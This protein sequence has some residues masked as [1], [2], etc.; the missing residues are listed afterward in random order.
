M[1]TTE[2]IDIKSLIKRK[3]DQYTQEHTESDHT[4]HIPVMGLAFTIDAPAKVG[5]FGISSVLSIIEDRLI[6]MMRANYYPKLGL[7]YEPITKQEPD[8]RA[9]RV[10]DYLNLLQATVYDQ[11]SKLKT[12]A[13][14]IG[15]EISKYFEMLPNDSIV[16]NMY[17]DM[18]AC[19]HPSERAE[20]Q[21]QLRKKIVAGRID[22][23]ILTKVDGE[24]Y[25]KNGDLIV[26]GSNAVAVLR[27]YIKSD[28]IN[29]S[30]CLSAGMNPRLYG[31]MENKEAF[32]PNEKSQFNKKVIIKVS[33]YRSALIQG[34]FLAKKGVWVS[35]FRIESGLNCGGH[36]F[37]T[38]GYLLGPV[39][40]ELKQNRAQLIEEMF[41]I[42]QPAIAEKTGMNLKTVPEVLVSVQ[43]GIGTYEE[44]TFLRK[45][46]DIAST[47]WGSPFLLV[48]EATTVDDYS[49][50]LLSKATEKDVH[51]SE[52]SPMGIPFYYLNGTTADQNKR[53]LINE[54][55]PGSP[56]PEKLLQFNTEFTERPICAASAKYQK[57]KLDKLQTEGLSDED[58]EEKKSQV[59]A[60][61]C[62]C[63]GLSNAATL[64][65]DGNFVKNFKI[66]NVCPGPNIA[67]F[68]KVVPL[69][70]MVDHIYGRT[71]LVTN[72]E[73]AHMFIAEMKIYIQYLRDEIKKGKGDINIPKR[74]S[75][76][77]TF[78]SNMLNAVA[79]YR[80]LAEQS[81]ISQKSFSKELNL[82][83]A[84]IENISE[85][86][87][88]S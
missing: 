44:D 81:L 77:K 49:L 71:D 1:K 15:T 30:I 8:Y 5:R 43:G 19:P 27:G 63:V 7:P 6:E 62:L 72:K 70:E 67:N 61:D 48:P 36:A 38:T 13:F 64:R 54:G 16:K 23:N 22:V 10:T 42:Y 84:E 78:V 29:S 24:T 88:L 2:N 82:A 41:T 53:T 9:K 40:E 87:Q 4:F 69:Q 33:D 17:L 26:D 86:Y 18:I 25:D 28:L 57:L 11:V 79:Y 32:Y 68:S 58:Y 85:T 59:L 21:A 46:Y 39:L 73:R 74:K 14:E 76:Y 31:Y 12:E 20:K 80:D 52:F 66:V 34:K 35:E 45:H 60:K 65:Y 37:A 50:Q 83:A 47:G 55:N 75:Y 3:I 51:L 56:C